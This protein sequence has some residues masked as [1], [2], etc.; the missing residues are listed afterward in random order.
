VNAFSVRFMITSTEGIQ[1]TKVLP[2]PVIWRVTPMR[3]QD[4]L[5]VWTCFRR[6]TEVFFNP[7]VPGHL[8]ECL[9]PDELARLRVHNRQ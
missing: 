7:S 2:S 5:G 4:H 8:M 9:G 1:Q 3:L 6:L